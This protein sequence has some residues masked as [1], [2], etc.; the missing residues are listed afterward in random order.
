MKYIQ[1][2]LRESLSL[3]NNDCSM[4]GDMA[5]IISNIEKCLEYI[6]KG[7]IPCTIKEGDLIG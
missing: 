3:L 6:R 7:A 1:K 4:I 5:L 2:L